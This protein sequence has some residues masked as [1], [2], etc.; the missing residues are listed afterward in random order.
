MCIENQMWKKNWIQKIIKYVV[1][2]EHFDWLEVE[3][4]LEL[5]ELNGVEVEMKLELIKKLGSE[6]WQWG[7]KLDLKCL[8][9]EM[10]KGESLIR[11]RSAI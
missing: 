2:V 1:D 3:M 8:L 6:K 5:N 7:M 9:L 11:F 4:E 10:T